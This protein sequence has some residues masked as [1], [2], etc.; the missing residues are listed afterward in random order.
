MVRAVAVPAPV[1]RAGPLE[2]NTVFNHF[3]FFVLAILIA[4]VP[5]NA[6]SLFDTPGSNPATNRCDLYDPN[7]K[8]RQLFVRPPAPVSKNNPLG[9]PAPKLIL[10]R[11][12]NDRSAKPSPLLHLPDQPKRRIYRALLCSDARRVIQMEGYRKIRT[13]KC[14]GKYHHFTAKRRGAKFAVNLKV[15]ATTGQI[16]VAGRSR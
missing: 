2:R 4:T 12:Q 9:A 5:A 11:D 10:P 3:A 8:P 1:K 6:G 15:R 14:G 7:C 16:I 13:L